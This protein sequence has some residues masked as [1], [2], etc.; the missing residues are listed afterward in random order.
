MRTS[1]RYAPGHGALKRSTTKFLARSFVECVTSSYE[2]SLSHKATKKQSSQGSLQPSSQ[3]FFPFCP[4]LREKVLG[5]R[6]DSLSG[7]QVYERL[8][9][10]PIT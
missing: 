10:L 8:A 6:M 4:F 7:P 1:W 2:R 3:G 9:V 5:R